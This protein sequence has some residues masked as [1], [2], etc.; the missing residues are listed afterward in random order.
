MI[1]SKIAEI[2]FYFWILK[3]LATTLGETTGDMLAHTLNMGYTLCLLVTGVILVGL[4]T[5]Q[6]RSK[7]CHSVIFWSAIIG[8]TTVGTEISDFMDRTLGLGYLWGSLILLCGLLGTLA[9][10]YVKSKNLKVYPM[11]RKDSELMFWIAVLFSNSLGTAFGDYLTDNVGLSY[12]EGALVTASVIGTVIFLHHSTRINQIFLFWIAFVFTR[13]FGA[14]FGDFLTK[15]LI[16]GG[17]DLGT[18]N[19]SLV[20]FCIFS[21]V[22]YISKQSS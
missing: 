9:V 3:V 4:L 7:K 5:M 6:V 14:T 11:I 22:I 20:T 17:L 2:T 19:A 15:P 21:A 16:H 1:K 13:P 8:T 18:I 10:W 12:I